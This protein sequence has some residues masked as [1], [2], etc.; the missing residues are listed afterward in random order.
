MPEEET[1]TTKPSRRRRWAG[2]AALLAS[3]AVAG[4]IVAGTTGASAATPT[5]SYGTQTNGEQPGGGG[6]QPTPGADGSNP[7]RSDEKAV[8]AA[9]EATLKAAAL[10]AV[11]GATVNRVETDAGDAAYEVHLTKSDGTRVTAKFDANLKFIKVED[12]MGLGDP[13]DG[14]GSRHG[15]GA[16]STSGSG[17]GA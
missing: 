15:G 17:Y 16:P 8:T 2:V 12:G 3:G 7:V 11:P 14:N 1:S 9:Q 6:G 4:G 13:Q 5:P 10:A